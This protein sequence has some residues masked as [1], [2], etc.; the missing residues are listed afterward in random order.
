MSDV[1][2]IKN[3]KKIQV[4]KEVC[5][6]VESVDAAHLVECLPSIHEALGFDLG[7]I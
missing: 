5:F 4:R 7:T 2:E 3:R 1:L 6:L